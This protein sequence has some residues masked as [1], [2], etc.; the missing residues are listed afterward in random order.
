MFL[1]LVARLACP[2]TVV[3]ATARM[4]L[5]VVDGSTRGVASMIETAEYLARGERRIAVVMQDLADPTLIH[6]SADPEQ[7]HKISGS[8][9]KD[10][11]RG[12]R[13]L[14]DLAARQGFTVHSDIMAALTS[15]REELRAPPSSAGR[16]AEPANE[17]AA[18]ITM[19]E[20]ADPA[21]TA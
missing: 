2:L 21:A 10:I 16:A 6:D 1:A 7:P 4:L 5:F 18:A 3:Q 11:N 15:I 20:L 9:L 12:R 13:F 8:E 19:P 17:P 14:E